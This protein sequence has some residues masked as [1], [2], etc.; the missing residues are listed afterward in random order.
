MPDAPNLG[1]R[2]NATVIVCDG[3][4][5]VLL[6]ERITWVYHALQTVQGGID[7]G[8]TAEMAAV[9]EV[10]EEIG[11][12]SGQYQ[13]QGPLDFTWKYIWPDGYVTSLGRSE[14]IGQE[15]TYFLAT[16][17]QEVEFDLDTHSREFKRVWWGTPQE[18]VD[19]SWE[20][21]RGGIER[22]LKEFGLLK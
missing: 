8:E 9:R 5:Q 13:L 1:Y 6:C 16:V 19:G 2:P 11:L 7:A 3:H 17:N 18:L 12:D 10:K 20:L 4:G 15:Q 14:Y 22:A 21:K